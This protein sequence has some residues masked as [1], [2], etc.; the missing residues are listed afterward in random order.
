MKKKTQM[1]RFMDYEVAIRIKDE[2]EFNQLMDMV[3]KADWNIQLCWEFKPSL[4]I[5]KRYD[6]FSLIRHTEEESRVRMLTVEDFNQSEKQQPIPRVLVNGNATIVWFE[7]GDKVVV[8]HTDDLPYDQEKAIAMACAKKLLGGYSKFQELM[9]IAEGGKKFAIV[10][11]AGLRYPT[12]YGFFGV[13]GLD[14]YAKDYPC[15]TDTKNWGLKSD[16]LPYNSERVEVL[17]EYPKPHES[18][19]IIVVVRKSNG[20]IGLIDKKGLKFL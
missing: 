14:K 15:K 5:I 20:V 19:T 7:D 16:I 11:D 4:I 13:Y 3:R 18:D 17:A 8:K 2:K 12:Y 9:G 10:V 1:E 6:R